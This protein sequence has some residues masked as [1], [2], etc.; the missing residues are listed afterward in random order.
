MTSPAHPIASAPL[1]GAP[2]PV[3]W[4]SWPM[5]EGGAPVWLFL[6]AS[7]VVGG[8][9]AA[10]T[11]NSGWA[12]AA[13]VLIGVAAWRLFVPVVFEVS[14]LGVTEQ[15]LSRR[16]RI[17]WSMIERVEIGREG[18]YLGL[19][20]A[21]LAALRG[22]YVPWGAH[23]DEVLAQVAYYL[24]A[25]RTAMIGPRQDREKPLPDYDARTA[26][27]VAAVRGTESQE[28]PPARAGD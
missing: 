3:A 19:E 1:R 11:G 20:S 23:R 9:T 10:V 5:A 18:V 26:A 13:V 7:A 28:E 4:R 21:P 24:P 22:L 25:H 15:V 6:A 16:R 8:A 27:R 2:P 17:P 14:A 12:A